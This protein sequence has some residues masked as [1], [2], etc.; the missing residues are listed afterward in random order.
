MILNA[1]YSALLVPFIKDFREASNEKER[2]TVISMAVAVVKRS[3][4]LLEDA[5]D[6]PKDL[7]TVCLPI[8]LA[9]LCS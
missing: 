4:A 3:K 6:L 2:K 1:T 5:G 8:C 7:P 9:F